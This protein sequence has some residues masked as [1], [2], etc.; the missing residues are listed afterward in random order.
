[1]AE[2]KPEVKPKPKRIEAPAGPYI[3]KSDKKEQK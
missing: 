3:S 2:K 1:M